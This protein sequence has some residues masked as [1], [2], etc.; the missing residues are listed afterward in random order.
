M[1]NISQDGRRSRHEPHKQELVAAV[2]EYG[3]QHGL[4]ELSIRPLA[5]CAWRQ[6]SH[7]AL[8]TLAQRRSYL[9]KYSRRL[10][11]CERLLFAFRF[12]DQETISVVEFVGA[13]F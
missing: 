7:V 2:V 1:K 8:M 3:V 4:S 11:L 13:A 5:V 12:R 9:S 10:V 6:P